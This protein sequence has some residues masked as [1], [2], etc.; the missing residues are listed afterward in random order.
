MTKDRTA[1]TLQRE[2]SAAR[3]LIAELQS[4]DAQLTHDMVEGETGLLE[5]VTA[6][7]DEIDDC[8]I[9]ITGCKEKERQIADRR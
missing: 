6:A 7:L 4:N 8:E 1:E 2:S 3:D 9:I 5:A